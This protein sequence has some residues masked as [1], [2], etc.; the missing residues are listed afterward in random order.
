MTHL[1]H[2]G[3]SLGVRI[4]KTIISELGFRE[5]TSLVFKVTGRGLLITP[6]KLRRDGWTEAFAVKR[7]GKKE[8]LFMGK[9]IANQFDQDEWEW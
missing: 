7:K 9:E 2:I 1:I 5:D 6:K 4:P 8:Q 3:N